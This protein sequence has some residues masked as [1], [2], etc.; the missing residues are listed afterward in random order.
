MPCRRDG[1]PIRIFSHRKV[2][3]T[4]GKRKHQD[5]TVNLDMPFEEAIRRL[6]KRGGSQ[7][8]ETGSTKSPAARSPARTKR[9]TA[10]RRKSSGD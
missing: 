1:Y 7:A 2:Y 8:A 9:K 3:M 4:T 5:T 6:S 10:R